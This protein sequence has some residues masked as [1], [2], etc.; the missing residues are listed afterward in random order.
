[1][2]KKIGIILAAGSGERFGSAAPKQF[3]K[4]AGKTILEHTLDVF[5]KSRYIDEMI[6][7][8]NAAYRIEVENI[9]LRNNYKKLKS[10]VNGGSTRQESTWVAVSQVDDKDY[11]IIH[12]A[13]RPFLSEK[14]ICNCVEA[15]E[16]YSAVDV[17]IPSADTIIEVKDRLISKIPPRNNFMRGQTP[18]AFRAGV[19]KKAHELARAGS[20]TTFTDD[21]GLVLKYRLADVFIALGEES[22]FKLTYPEDILLAEILFQ[23]RQEHAEEGNYKLDDLKNKVIVVFGASKGIGQVVC[24]VASANG[25]RVHGFSRSDKVDVSDYVAVCA[26]LK[27]VFERE[28]RIDAVIVTAGVLKIGKLEDRDHEEIV[29]EININYL[30]SINAAKAAIPYLKKTRGTL[31]LFTSSSYTRGRALYATYS[32]S[33]AAIVNLTQALAEELSHDSI[34]VNCINPERAATPMRFANFGKENPADLL[35][36]EKIACATLQ[37][38]LSSQTGRIVMVRK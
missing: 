13:V 12:D 10:V 30:G 15:L 26:V 28:G 22:N 1:M 8:I 9:I 18:Q 20:D 32:S 33:K 11:V 23:V 2:A 19:I 4:I 24:S 25:A 17:A 36:P 16:N 5:E 27:T 7:V 35:D 3:T 38:V 34:R 14:I 21:C 6:L 31:V 29:D 37:V